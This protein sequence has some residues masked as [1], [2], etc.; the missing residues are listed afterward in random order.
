MELKIVESLRVKRMK[1][2]SFP[3]E[4]NKMILKIISLKIV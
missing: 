1:A 3:A 2:L 4:L